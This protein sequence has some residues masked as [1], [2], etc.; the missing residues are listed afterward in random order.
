MKKKL[1]SLAMLVT[2]LAMQVVGVSAASKTA[3]MAVVGNSKGYYEVDAMDQEELEKLELE[4]LEMRNRDVKSLMKELKIGGLTIKNVYLRLF[5]AY[6]NN[7]IFDISNKSE[8][9][10]I[11][12]GENYENTCTGS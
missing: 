6:G 2:V 5:L 7:M 12:V 11:T 3:T 1:I 9:M 10:C 8:G 4:L